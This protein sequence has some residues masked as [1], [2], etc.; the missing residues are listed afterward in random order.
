MVALLNAGGLLMHPFV[1]AEIALGNPPRRAVTLAT[2]GAI[3]Q[4]VIAS[5][6]ELR[7]MIEKH[8][9]FGS[10][11]GYVDAHLIASTMLTAG[12]KLWTGDKRLHAVAERLGVSAA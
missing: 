11:V 10:G 9:I 3:R 5:N 8:T 2:L 7:R 4:P 6:T 12:A 1:L